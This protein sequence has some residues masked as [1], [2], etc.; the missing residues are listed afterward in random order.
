MKGVLLPGSRRVSVETF[1]DPEPVEDQVLVRIVTAGICG[2]DMHMFR[3]SPDRRGEAAKVIVGHEGAGIVEA[4]GPWVRGFEPGDKAIVYMSWGCGGCSFCLNGLMSAC[5]K[6]DKMGITVNGA[7]AEYL[8]APQRQIIP[9][10]DGVTC[11]QA[12]LTSC[13][14]A[15]AY[16]ALSRIGV[17]GRDTVALFGMGPLGLCG[18]LFAKAMG[19]RTIAVE[20]EQYRLELAAKLDADVLLDPAVVDVPGK[21]KDLTHGKGA[22]AALDFSGNEQGQRQTLES[23]CYFGRAAFVGLNQKNLLLEP[24]KHIMERQTTLIGSIIPPKG[25]YEKTFEFIGDRRVPLE[26]LA[27][28]RFHLEDA[29]EAFDLHESGKAGKIVFEA[30]SSD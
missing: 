10:P 8:L 5:E 7:D 30:D 22:D 23:V 9:V 19:A 1:P 18:L 13:I 4:V 2:S 16:R 29:P 20:V 11:L 12:T 26:E 15:T 24:T 3:Q 6:R 28:H 27:T 21:I 17:S 25:D 14:G